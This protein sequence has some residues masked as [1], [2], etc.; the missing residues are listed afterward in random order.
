[1]WPI[2]IIYKVQKCFCCTGEL[3]QYIQTFSSASYLIIH[4]V[5]NRGVYSCLWVGIHIPTY[6]YILS[7]W[8]CRRLSLSPTIIH[9]NIFHIKHVGKYH[10]YIM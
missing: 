6:N 8:F 4:I 9:V 1:M 5:E 2:E 3:N 10:F 7:E